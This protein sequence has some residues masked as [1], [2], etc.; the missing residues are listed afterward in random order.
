MYKATRDFINARQKFA[1]FEV[2]AVSV[3]QIGGGAADSSYM[4]AHGRIDRERNIRIVSGWLVKPYNRMLKKT[5]ILQHWWNVDANTRTYFD[6]SPD[7]GRDC[8]YVL[9]MDLA[10]FGIRNFDDPAGIVCYAVHLRDGKYTM[11]DRIFGELF[12]KSI[13]TLETASLFKKV[14]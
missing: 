7:V 3:Q 12:Y 2:K 11:V 4:N 6:V 8:E 10:E 9:D 5:E 1:R 14:I 13:E